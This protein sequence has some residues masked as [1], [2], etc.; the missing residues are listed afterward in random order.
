LKAIKIFQID[1][2]MS[3]L[4]PLEVKGVIDMWVGTYEQFAFWSLRFL[5][6]ALLAF[7]FKKL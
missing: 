6:I 1:E 5:D 2:T 7:H 4:C 3:K